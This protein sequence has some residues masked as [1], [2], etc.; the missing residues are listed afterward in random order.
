M[1]SIELVTRELEPVTRGF[2]L[3]TRGFELVTRVL[4]FRYRNVFHLLKCTVLFYGFFQ[5]AFLDEAK[6]G[7]GIND[8]GK[9]CY[10]VFL[11]GNL[12][13]FKKITVNGLDIIQA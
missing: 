4:L 1:D 11:I 12:C 9:N 7:I 5:T 8:Q 13:S 6:L 10:M 2:G 3:V